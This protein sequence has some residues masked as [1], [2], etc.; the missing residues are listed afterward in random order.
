MNRN[1]NSHFALAPKR[2][3]MP[4][5]RIDTSFSNLTT[6][7]TGDLIPLCRPLEILPGDTLTMDT[8]KVIRMQ[9]LIAP[10]FSNLYLDVYW[11]FV[12]HRLVH[13]HF[14]E[15]MGENN[16]S[17]WI[18]SVEYTVP[19]VEAPSGGWSKGSLAD[20]FGIP[21]GVDGFSVSAY[22]FRS[23]CKI[24]NDWFRS[25]VLSDPV[26]LPLGD[27][28]ITGNNGTDP[29]TDLVKGGMPYKACKFFDQF[30]GCLPEPQKGSAVVAPL[31]GSAPVYGMDNEPLILRS[32]AKIGDVITQ[33]AYDR[34][35]GS[36]YTG[37]PGGELASM[38][39]NWAQSKVT[40]LPYKGNV[41]LASP[42]DP[43]SNTLM[44]V[45]S[46]EKVDSTHNTTLYADLNTIQ[47]VDINSLRLGF[48]LQKL[49]ERDARSGTRYIELIKAH[50]SVDSPDARLQRSEYLGGSR[51]P[52]HIN[53]VVQ[54]SETGSTPQG[55]V[56]AYSL[57]SDYHS[58]FTKSFTEHGYVI[59]LGVVRYDHC[60]QQGLDELW[61]RKSRFDFYW[62][63]LSCISE[64]PIYTRTL[65]LPAYQAAVPGVSDEVNPIF[66]FQ[67]AWSSYRYQNNMISGEMR[68]DYTVSLDC[69]HLAD[70]Y[71][72]R[73]YLSDSWIRE[74]ASIV[75][76]VLAV[77]GNV[78]DQF[79]G[80][81]FFKMKFTRCM[82]LYSIPGL[83]D[84]F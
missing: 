52:I 8:A 36:S 17:P 82:P 56:T 79:M 61:T 48:Q 38:N 47:G 29:V 63:V 15:V 73:P 24:V 6:F 37:L 57:T 55:N 83:I 34:Y 70:D 20:H 69:W 18:P 42:S 21:I 45:I 54:N 65:Y 5:S 46:K 58:D 68:S 77:S 23:Y 75:D 22:P 27:S 59:G 72:A 35:V 62:P 66:G 78:A 32:L 44:N 26:N 40:N 84:H 71:T 12:P 31:L 19:Q 53:Q 2:N 60:Y 1:Q 13:E 7:N 10:I 14:K 41:S 74:D 11:F 67:E 50:F 16:S 81:F 28:N 39:L 33:G 9:T 25:E 3:D 80:D 51:I 4:R 43:E 49:L 76:R 64:Q 30:T